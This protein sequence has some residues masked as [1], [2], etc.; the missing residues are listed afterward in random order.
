MPCAWL[1]VL[2]IQFL[3]AACPRAPLAAGNLPF[4]GVPYDIVEEM[5][6]VGLRGGP[7]LPPRIPPAREPA[8]LGLH[9]NLPWCRQAEPAGSVPT[10]CLLRQ[11][12]GS[13]G[14][15][16]QGSAHTCPTT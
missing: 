12:C 8:A 2:S 7:C 1:V 9:T 13:R 3:S 5:D 10:R 14:A 11:P 6:E 15:Q 16:T 4:A